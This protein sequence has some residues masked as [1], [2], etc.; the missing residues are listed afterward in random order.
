MI[1]DTLDNAARYFGLSEHIALALQY[2]KDNNCTKLAVGKTPIRGDQI[3]AIV[4]DNTSKASG[5]RIENMS[6][7]SLSPPASRRWGMQT[8][9]R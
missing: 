5:R 6:T 7:C 4:A 2:L 3:Y 1:V 8:S 9:R